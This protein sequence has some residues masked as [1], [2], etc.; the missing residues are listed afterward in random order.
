MVR[1]ARSQAADGGSHIL[2]G[3]AGLTLDRRGK[4]VAGRRTILEIYRGRQPVR[5]NGAVESG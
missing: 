3:V 2:I 1:G 4:P 5:I